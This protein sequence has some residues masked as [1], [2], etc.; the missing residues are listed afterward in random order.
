MGSVAG[1]MDCRM[2]DFERY[3]Q[4]YCKFLM[5]R[6]LREVEQR[7]VIA[8]LVHRSDA[9]FTVSEL[10]RVAETTPGVY[11]LSKPTVYRLL[12][13][14]KQAG[15]VAPVDCENGLGFVRILSAS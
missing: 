6:G 11:R 13:E 5:E 3:Y 14:M 2:T 12:G 1:G 8:K 4:A 10:L 9:P 15:L 7:R